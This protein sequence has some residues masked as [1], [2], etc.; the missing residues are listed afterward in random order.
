LL[1]H[2]VEAALASKIN[3]DTGAFIYPPVHP[4]IA[5]PHIKRYGGHLFSASKN[6]IQHLARM[7]PDLTS[8][9]AYLS[10]F[11]LF[12][13]TA[14]YQV[15]MNDLQGELDH[16]SMDLAVVEGLLREVYSFN[17]SIMDRMQQPMASSVKWRNALD[18]LGEDGAPKQIEV[19]GMDANL[20]MTFGGIPFQL[21]PDWL[22]FF[23]MEAGFGGGAI[24]A[25][26]TDT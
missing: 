14:V 10:A 8:M 7:R 19:Q 4:D 1:S 20:P 13:Y 3:A 2:I 26:F 21:E 23:S 12:A 17:R 22:T 24:H 16:L 18:H 15:K 5:F 9:P 6:I 25:A 11:V